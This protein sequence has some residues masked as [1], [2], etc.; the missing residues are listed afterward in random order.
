LIDIKEVGTAEATR[1]FESLSARVKGSIKEKGDQIR[2][3]V[4]DSRFENVNDRLQDVKSAE[5]ELKGILGLDVSKLQYKTIITEITDKVYKEEVAVATAAV[6]NK[7]ADTL[8][9]KMIYLSRLSE[10]MPIIATFFQ[11]NV[12]AIL[13][14]AK[15]RNFIG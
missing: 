14:E 10:L 6:A 1:V 11:E 12:A 13:K 9:K 7:N 3:E 8:V 2:A 4:S 5:E 15:L